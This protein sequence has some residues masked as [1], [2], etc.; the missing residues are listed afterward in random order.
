MAEEDPDLEEVAEEGDIDNDKDDSA[1][2]SREMS[3]DA[4]LLLGERIVSVK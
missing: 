1:E 4:L 2:G 3:Y